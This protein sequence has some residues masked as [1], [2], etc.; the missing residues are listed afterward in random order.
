MINIIIQQ[1]FVLF[2][3]Y[4]KDKNISEA[5]N[6]LNLIKETLNPA[7]GENYAILQ[8]HEAVVFVFRKQFN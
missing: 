7:I 6:T 3:I 4:Y 5:R 8:M 2:E 1:N